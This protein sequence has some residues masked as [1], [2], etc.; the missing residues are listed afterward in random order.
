LKLL[1][2]DLSFNGDSWEKQL[3]PVLKFV[4]DIQEEPVYLDWLKFLARY[5]YTCSYDNRQ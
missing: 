5:F 2:V 3:Q 4:Q 1:D